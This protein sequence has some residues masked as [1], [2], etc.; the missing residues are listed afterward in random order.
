[1]GESG[2]VGSSFNAIWSSLDLHLRNK[3]E[4]DKYKINH[5]RREGDKGGRKRG[6]VREKETRDKD[7]KKIDR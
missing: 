3:G 5:C 7:Y 1:M 2:E 4:Y 6:R